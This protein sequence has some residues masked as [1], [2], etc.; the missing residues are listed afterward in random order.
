MLQK[1]NKYAI[2]KEKAKTFRKA[3]NMTRGGDRLGAGRPKVKPK[4]KL[5]HTVRLNDS[6]KDFI[7]FS[8]VKKIDLTKLKKTLLAFATILFIC[9][10]VNAYT[11]KGGVEYT[12]DEAR[13]V[14]FDNSPVKISKE[15]FS[16][17]INDKFY[18][19]SIGYIN[20]RISEAVARKIVPFYENNKLSFYGVQYDQDPS[21]KYYYSPSGKLLKYEVNTFSG[22]YPYKTLA[23]DTQGK[24][25]NI[26]LVVS[27]Q[28]SFLFDKN[29]KLIGHWVNN[30]FYD[31]NGNKDITR[32]L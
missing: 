31:A 12:V 14:A 9:M 30:Q 28:E 19:S 29:K 25:L 21:K 4:E 18:F 15:E 32:R 1:S 7:L 26:N 20:G 10:P 11:L 17:N 6:E 22:S 2:L 3:V 8:R 27:N 16:A 5:S 24:L 23:Y 13:V